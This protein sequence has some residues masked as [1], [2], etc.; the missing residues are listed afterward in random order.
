MD[1][2]D[3]SLALSKSELLRFCS[4]NFRSLGS[5]SAHRT[6]PEPTLLYVLFLQRQ[7]YL[8][9]SSMLYRY[10]CR[11]SG[12]L[13]RPF[14]RTSASRCRA[15]LF[16][17]A[18]LVLRLVRAVAFGESSGDTGRYLAADEEVV[19]LR[20]RCSNRQLDSQNPPQVI[21]ILHITA[22]PSPSS[23]PSPKP[24]YPPDFCTPATPPPEPPPAAHTD[25]PNSTTVDSSP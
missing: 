3:I 18:S 5:Y 22:R 9:R 4:Q 23:A 1:H 19:V 2:G 21:D 6:L 14:D 15:A 11:C 7:S 17:L 16:D 13:C 25:K 24:T 20:V 10:R 12:R 8:P